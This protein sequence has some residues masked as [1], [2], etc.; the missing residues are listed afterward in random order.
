VLS[1]PGFR[2]LREREANFFAA[3]LL[4]PRQFLERDLEDVQYVE[5][6][7]RSRTEK[8]IVHYLY[9]AFVRT[10]KSGCGVKSTRDSN[11]GPPSGFDF[12]ASRSAALTLSK[13]SAFAAR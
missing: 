1:R 2:C 11:A 10:S 6:S 13:L 5:G 8:A 12:M 7:G 9:V 4:M 3:A